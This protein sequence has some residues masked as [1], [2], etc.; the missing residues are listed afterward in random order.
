M[1]LIMYIHNVQN[2]KKGYNIKVNEMVE[3]GC[4]EPVVTIIRRRSREQIVLSVKIG[5][6][7]G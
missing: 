4:E 5:R 6:D 2:H 3:A 7:R 1:A